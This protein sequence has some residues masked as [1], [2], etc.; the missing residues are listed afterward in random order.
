VLRE[1]GDQGAVAGRL[2]AIFCSQPVI[3][4]AAGEI[5]PHGWYLRELHGN[6]SGALEVMQMAYD[7]TPF[8]ESEDR[9]WLLTQM[10]HLSLL[11]GDLSKAEMWANG[12][13]GLFPNYHYALGTLAQVRIAQ[14]RYGEAVTLLEKR[15]AAAPHAEN[16]YA[17]A[18]ARELA[19]QKDDALQSYARFERQSLAETELADNSDHELIAYYVDHAHLPAKA[20]AIARREVARRQDVYTLD[21]YAWA[22]AG[23]GDYD[24]AEAQMEKALAVGV[25]DARLLFHAGAIALHLR[26]NDKAE[27]YLKD[28][29]SRHSHEALKLLRDMPGEPGA[30]LN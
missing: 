21:S 8:S 2:G 16:L 13:L 3:L 1:L 24:Q 25:K 27:M 7:S 30:G 29:A 5:L 17:L 22:L 11:G 28:A 12:A 15:Y 19:G 23:N 18:E 26:H 4:D 10:A 6:L 9:A 14:E 20:L